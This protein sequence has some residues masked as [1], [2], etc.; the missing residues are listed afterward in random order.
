MLEGLPADIPAGPHSFEITNSGAEPHVMVI[1]TKAEGVTESWDEIM[2]AAR[3]GPLRGD[4]RRVR[5]ARRRRVR[6]R[7]PARG[8]LHGPVPDPDRHDD[9]GRGL[10]R[11]IS[12]TA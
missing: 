8:R 1:L 3:V 4:G 6:R 7:R 2:A 5:P 12:S 10:A 11:R 9:G